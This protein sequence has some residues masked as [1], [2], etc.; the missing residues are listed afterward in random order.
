MRGEHRL[1]I[2]QP[3]SP[4]GIIPACAGSTVTTSADVSLLAGSSP[5][6]RGAPRPCWRLTRE[7]GDHPRMRGEHGHEVLVG[8]DVHGIIP[9]C[10][11]STAS[12]ALS[13][14][15]GL[16]SSPHA[17]GALR[18][19]CHGERNARD[20]PRMRG[21]HCHAEKVSLV[22]VRIIP[23]CAGS[24]KCSASCIASAFGIIPACAGSTSA[25]LPTRS[26]GVGSSP[27]ARGAR[28]HPSPCTAICRDHP[29]MRGEHAP[30]CPRM[31]SFEGDHPRMR[32]EHQSL[33]ACRAHVLRI[34]P[35]CAGSTS[36]T[37][38]RTRRHP[39]SSPHARGALPLS[40]EI[41]RTGPDH[42]R[43]RG[44]HRGLAGFF[45]SRHRIIPACAG[46]T[47]DAMQSTLG[48]MGSSPHARGAPETR[49]DG[50]KTRWDHPR[51]RGEHYRLIMSWL[52]IC[53]DHPRMRGEHRHAEAGE[54]V[55]LGIIPACAGS[56][57]LLWASA[58]SLSG[59]SPHARGA[60]RAARMSSSLPTDHPRMRGEHVD[61]G[62]KFYEPTVDHP[63][64]R[65]E[66]RGRYPQD[67]AEPG[68][69]PAC[70]GSTAGLPRYGTCVQG[71]SPHARGARL[72]FLLARFWW[73]DHPRMRGEHGT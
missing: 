35:A 62:G 56:T 30:H 50:R 68:I 14:S 19:R 61:R 25:A 48:W 38:P 40:H 51:M 72:A 69:I 33:N 13:F 73:R 55:S 24:T 27:H 1:N 15:R 52:C 2:H 36:S 9:A 34:I 59:S 26:R 3:S 7:S 64:M 29:R 23:A 28:A 39:G 60:P 6:A 16:G 10:A 66:H 18:F 44:E 11:G 20:H 46:S 17:R 4:L 70:A 12:T 71:S 21:E 41:V 67:P 5:H 58:G 65:G 43:M 54:A 22:Y 8:T 53:Q 49:L 47:P 31:S 42:P 37:A 57:F 63:R 45:G 32:G